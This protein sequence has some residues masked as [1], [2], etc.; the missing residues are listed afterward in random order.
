M[1]SNPVMS[2]FF[3]GISRQNKRYTNMDSA[4]PV[5]LEFR[6]SDRSSRTAWV[7]IPSFTCFI[8]ANIILFSQ[9]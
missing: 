4:I 7:Q 5:G 6:E 2:N 3:A 1:S 9:F 8:I